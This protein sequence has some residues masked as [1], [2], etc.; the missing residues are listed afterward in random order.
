MTAFRDPIAW[1]PFLLGFVAVAAIAHIGTILAYP[2]H[3]RNDAFER[4]AALVPAEG[5]TDL[6]AAVVRNGL[7]SRDAAMADSICRF[8]L[9]RGP[10]QITIEPFA[11]GFLSVG[12]HSR[13]GLAFYGLN[14]HANESR[15]IRLVLMTDAQRTKIEA[16]DDE[17]EPSQDL[18]VTAP[19]RQ[20]FV[21]VEAPSADRVTSVDTLAHVACQPM[22]SDQGSPVPER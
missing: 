13:H 22:T 10:Y 19:E 11:A 6:P 14:L 18:R 21:L 9:G 15:A 7:P 2:R 20:G 4:I 8:D 1:V 12:M 16:D 3:A 5:K 17:D